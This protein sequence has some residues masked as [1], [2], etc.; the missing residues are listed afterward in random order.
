MPLHPARRLPLRRRAISYDAVTSVIAAS[1]RPCFRPPHPHPHRQTPGRGAGAPRSLALSCGACGGRSCL[2][3]HHVLTMSW[4]GQKYVALVDHGSWHTVFER[5]PPA[6]INIYACNRSVLWR[7]RAHK[8]QKWTLIV[9]RA[10]A[11][12]SSG[13]TKKNGTAQRS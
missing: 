9:T 12:K 7:T 4:L 13:Q 1:R 10:P 3:T 2:F 8:R 5:N 6:C 11:L